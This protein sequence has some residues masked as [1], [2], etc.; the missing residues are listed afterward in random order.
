MPFRAAF[1]CLWCGKPWRTRTDS[2]LEGWAGLCPDCLGR[3]DDNGF[4]AFRLRS[5]LAERARASGV[6]VPEGPPPAERLGLPPVSSAQLEADARAW[7]AALGAGWD[8]RYT[9]A[10]RYRRGPVRDLAWQMELDTVTTW[11]DR[12]PLHGEIVELAAGTGWWSTL[13]AGKGELSI[14]DVNEAVLD[15][16]RRRLVA[17][18]LRA[19]L[20]VRDAWEEPDRA[21]DAVVVGF[22]LSLVPNDR[23]ERF[24]R[25]VR[26]WLRPGGV[27]AFIDRKGDP[28]AEAV[29][30]PAPEQGVVRRTLPDGREVLV[31]QVVRT[32]EELDGA[33]V[34]AG[35][36]SAEVGETARFFVMGVARR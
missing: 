33:L 35:F 1:D 12:L 30:E 6:P 32:P 22:W 7:F 16:A 8:D 24:L 11:L 29:D 10:G 34:E 2:D 13:L 14:Y 18:G 17:H 25:L 20:H 27:F 15:V 5:G 28:D 19:H 31:P 4:I 9:R 3:A 36:A 21:V 23:L 26:T